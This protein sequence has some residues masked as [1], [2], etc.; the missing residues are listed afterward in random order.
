M[1]LLAALDRLIPAYSPGPDFAAVAARMGR[2]IPWEYDFKFDA[3]LNRTAG[4]PD[5]R[6]F[7]HDNA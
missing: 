2:V 1:D 4:L 7:W 3:Q 5:L 6:S